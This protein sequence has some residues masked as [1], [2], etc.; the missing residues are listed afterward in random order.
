MPRRR[1]YAGGTTLSSRHEWYTI[2]RR[3]LERDDHICQLKA[4]GCEGD[5]LEV[6]HRVEQ[7]EGGT[8]DDD[9]LIS[10]CAPCH[11]RLTIEHNRKLARQRAEQKKQLKRSQHPG[12]K[13]D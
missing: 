5:A 9:N 1:K 12:I 10:L 3:I 13:K 8:D 7:S 2:R 11:S 6:H 4:Y